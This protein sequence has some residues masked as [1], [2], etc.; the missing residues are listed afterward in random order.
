MWSTFEKQQM[1]RN[2]NVPK[3]IFVR[4]L[5]IWYHTWDWGLGVRI[6]TTDTTRRL[7]E[8]SSFAFWHDI[9]MYHWLVL[10]IACRNLHSA[11]HCKMEI[12]IQYSIWNSWKIGLLRKFGI[13]NSIRFVLFDIQQQFMFLTTCY[14]LYCDPSNYN[15]FIICYAKTIV[16]LYCTS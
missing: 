10:Q 8:S 12:F 4:R 9:L 2:R 3:Y 14:V 6:N 5:Y 11:K 13:L 1:N 7:F 16:K 15:C